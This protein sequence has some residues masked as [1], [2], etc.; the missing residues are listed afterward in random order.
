MDAKNVFLLLLSDYVNERKIC[1]I[2]NKNINYEQVYHV[3]E[4]HSLLGILAA[5]SNKYSLT[6]PIELAKKMNLYLASSVMQSVNWDNL[7]FEL[8]AAFEK[9]NI[10]NIIV[11]GPVVK[12]YYPDPD[13]RTMGDLDFVIQ[14]KDIVNAQKI[15]QAKG[16]VA[17]E[18]CIDEYKFVRNGL[19]V[20]LHEDLTSKDFGTGIDYKQ[21]M[22][23]IFKAVKDKNK[24][25]QELTDECH[26]LYLILHIAQHLISE[27]CGIR[28]IL[29]VALFVK[30]SAVSMDAA[31]ELLRK[32]NLEDLAHNIFFL[33]NKWFDVKCDEYTAPDE[34]CQTLSDY[35]IDGGTFGFNA[36]RENNLLYR[37]ELQKGSKLRVLL[38]RVFPSK[39]EARSKV[40]WYKNKPDWLLPVA[41]VMRWINLCMTNP[42]RVK[43]YF[44]SLFK[45]NKS[46][47]KEEYG[48]LKQ[49][50]FYKDKD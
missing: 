36:N 32:F 17:E 38:S 3:A 19:C 29:D 48:M 40:V 35:I 49:L 44:D 20:E 8:S 22:Q 33:C 34:L 27:G 45:N 9:E 21:E 24:I 50:G 26:L 18:G 25:S 16:F 41:W 15:M 47:T 6:F 4:I 23:F 46:V 10:R 31:W 39:E 7:Y 43:E 2:D 42:R 30:N 14:A 12:R 5:V 11:K 37:E 1:S 28:Q 13:L